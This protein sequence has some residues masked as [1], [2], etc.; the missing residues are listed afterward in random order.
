MATDHVSVRP[1]SAPESSLFTRNATGLVRAVTPRTAYILNFIAGHPVQPLAYGL[2]FA[3]ALFPGGNFFLGGLLTIPVTLAFAYAFGL[4][5]AMIPRTGGDYTIVTRTIHPLV[6]M[7]SSFCQNMAQFMSLAFFG[8]VVVT[9][10]LAPGLAGVGLI[11]HSHTL[12]DWGNSVQAHPAWKLLCG[13][14]IYAGAALMHAGGWRSTARLQAVVFSIVTGGLLLAGGI[15]L[16]TSNGTFIHNFNS[17]AQPFTHSRDSYHAVIAS[18]RAAGVR[19]N[20]PFSFSQTIALVGL[21]AQ[22]AIYSWF[23]AYI[24]GELR[25]G[26]STKTAN[27]MALGGVTA[28]IAAL[29]FGWIFIHTFGH[30][31]LAASNAGAGTGLGKALPT[32]PVYFFLIA[33][34]VGSPF[35]AWVF[36][37][38]YLLFWVML[39]FCVFT[40]PSRSLFAWA[41]DGLLP[42]WTTKVS[43]RRHAP[44]VALVAT[45]CLAMLCLFAFYNNAT[46]YQVIVYAVLIQLIS[47]GLVGVAAIVVPWR[48]PDLYRAAT[49]QRRVLRIPLVTWAGLAAVA[50]T[51]FLWVLFFVYENQYG[52][53]N[54][55]NL[56]IWVLG[57]IAAAVLFYFGATLVKRRQGVKLAKVYAEI[58]PE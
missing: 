56:A 15:A 38:T 17:F 5:T 22:F 10:G 40:C 7:I 44:W 12:V 8:I 30:D 36:L 34:S 3:F 54:K 57:T 45:F 52:L 51:V 14:V 20:Q 28:I 29:V 6:G 50:A 24:G 25:Q 23:S 49:T 11:S 43:K 32:S 9:L 35:L 16:F 48:R 41:F 42:K 13:A 18:N 58:P 2:F 39:S 1:E 46:F 31:F 33:A 26:R 37:I 47:M 27:V 55:T 4:M 19:V 53:A 21:F